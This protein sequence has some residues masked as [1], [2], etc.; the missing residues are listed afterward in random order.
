LK[1]ESEGD[2]L[3]LQLSCRD[4]EDARGFIDAAKTHEPSSIAYT[5]L[6]MVAI[7]CYARPCTMNEL[8]Y[9]KCGVGG[10]YPVV[11]PTLKVADPSNVLGEDAPLPTRVIEMRK[12]AVAHS[13]WGI[14]S[15]NTRSLRIG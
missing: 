2:L 14:A 5:A 7:I 13:E 10:G 4:F 8:P 9:R 11:S 15:T 1:N 12:K 3:R 6:V